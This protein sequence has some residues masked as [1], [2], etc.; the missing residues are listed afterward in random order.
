MTPS[1]SL[2]RSHALSLLLARYIAGEIADV[3]FNQFSELLDES[4]A[5]SEERAAFAR[6]YLDAV[7]SGSEVKMPKVNEIKDMLTI[8]RA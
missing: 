7:S 5:S 8:A 1:A 4:E 2:H 3:Q 6:F